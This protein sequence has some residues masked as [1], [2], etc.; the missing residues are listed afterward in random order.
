M[1]A[2][3]PSASHPSSTSPLPPSSSQRNHHPPPSSRPP[4]C[5]SH[6]PP[7]RGFQNSRPSQHNAPQQSQYRNSESNAPPHYG[8]DRQGPKA[9]PG[10]SHRQ[11]F[12]LADEEPG[13]VNRTG[14]GRGGPS[15]VV[16][17]IF[18]D[19]GGADEED[20]R[21]ASPLTSP[22]AGGRMPSPPPPRRHH[23]LE[24]RGVADRSGSS[25]PA[26]SDHRSTPATQEASPPAERPVE[27]KS[28][29]LARRTR[30]R[31][32]DLGSKQASVE[33]TPGVVPSPASTGG[34][35][36]AAGEGPGPTAAATPLAGLAGLDQA[37]MNLSG[38]NWSQNPT[39]YL[40]SELRGE[41]DT[42]SSLVIPCFESVFSVVKH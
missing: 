3:P 29:A 36:W 8:R 10:H 35:S 19:N 23:Q 25:A 20:F 17:E 13:V 6:A 5:N 21:T 9:E 34:K 7:N 11:G 42:T 31:P 15:V 1:G 18:S 38:P 41:G 16:E 27:R 40:R 2:P 12:S 14:R 26:A 37:R 32:A 33:E 24:Q 22:H 39:S 30:S 28:Y 4:P